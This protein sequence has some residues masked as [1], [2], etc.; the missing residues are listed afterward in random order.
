MDDGCAIPSAVSQ[1]FRLVA[2]VCRG[3]L[4]RLDAGCDA[5]PVARLRVRPVETVWRKPLIRFD[6]GRVVAWVVGQ[7]VRRK[8][9]PD[10]KRNVD[11][12]LRTWIGN[13]SRAANHGSRK[14]ASLLLRPR[15]LC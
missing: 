11:Q 10:S 15:H 1:R 9:G 6:A 13:G 12:L 2:T 3:P 5:P 8:Q 4:I 14:A 7:K